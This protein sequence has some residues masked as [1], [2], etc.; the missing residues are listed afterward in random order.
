MKVNA[1]KLLPLA[2]IS[3][4]S[5][6]AACGWHITAP[7]GRLS[8]GSSGGTVSGGGRLG[9]SASLSP[10]LPTWLP[11]SVSRFRPHPIRVMAFPSRA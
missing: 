2:G 7:G 10:S 11:P 3:T 4:H 6:N 9:A 5:Y 1:T 8:C